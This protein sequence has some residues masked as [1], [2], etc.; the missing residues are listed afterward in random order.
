MGISVA[1]RINQSRSDSGFGLSQFHYDRLE[2]HV[3]SCL[4]D[5]IK[6]PTGSG[7]QPG[8]RR[9]LLAS[10]DTELLSI[11]VHGFADYC[12]VDYLG[13]WYETINCGEPQTSKPYSAHGNGSSS[14]T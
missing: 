4:P 13:M 3:G 9:P 6:P 10:A 2:N 12:H 8:T 14:G 1:E 5:H 11:D 7:S